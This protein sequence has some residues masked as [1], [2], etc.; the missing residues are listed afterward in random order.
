MVLNTAT[1]ETYLTV[2][3][4]LNCLQMNG[5]LN[6]LLAPPDI[7]NQTEQLSVQLKQPNE[8]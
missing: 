6:T 8:S 7:H 3:T 5:V 1:P 4:S 2:P